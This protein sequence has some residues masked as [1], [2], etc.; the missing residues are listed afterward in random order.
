MISQDYCY[1]QRS[2]SLV[3]NDHAVLNPGVLIFRQHMPTYELTRSGIGTL[4]DDPISP[5]R[6]NPRE[7]RKVIFGGFVKIHR[8]LFGKAFFDT[9]GDGLGITFQ[10][11]RGFG[12]LL[13]HLIGA[14]VRRTAPAYS[15]DGS[16]DRAWN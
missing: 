11:L 4:G 7:C 13:A 1:D 5:L 8:L 16:D 2:L 9:F 6:G 10:G 12:G 3:S 15:Q 14:L